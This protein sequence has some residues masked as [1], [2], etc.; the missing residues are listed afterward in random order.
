MLQQTMPSGPRVRSS[1][2]TPQFHTCAINYNMLQKC[3]FPPNILGTEK[4][5]DI[6][7]PPAV[8]DHVYIMLRAH[9]CGNVLYIEEN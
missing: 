4:L 2:V 1:S 6:S 8:I 9:V 7:G 5:T 3:T